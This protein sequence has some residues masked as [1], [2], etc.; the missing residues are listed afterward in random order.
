MKICCGSRSSRGTHPDAP[1]L[2]LKATR[3]KQPH[4]THERSCKEASSGPSYPYHPIFFLPYVANSFFVFLRPAQKISNKPAAPIP[5]K[6]SAAERRRIS[7][8]ERIKEVE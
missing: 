4:K 5:A 8:K 6:R 1:G 2:L 7:R 3:K